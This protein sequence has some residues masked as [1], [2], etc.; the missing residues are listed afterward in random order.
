[1]HSSTLFRTL[2]FHGVNAVYKIAPWHP[3]TTGYDSTS[4][5]SD[6]DSQNLRN[7]GFN[8]VRLGVMW[9]GVEPGPRGQ[10]NQTYL[11]QIETIVTNLQTQGIYVILDFHQDL[12]HR[13][14][15]GEGVP[16]YVYDTCKRAEPADTKPFPLPAVNASYPLDENGDPALDSCLSHMFATYYLSAEVGAGF[17]CLYDNVDNLWDAFAGYWVAI[18]SRFKSFNNVLGYELMNEPWAGDVYKNPKSLLPHFAEQ[19]YLQPLYQHLHKVTSVFTFV[20][21]TLALTV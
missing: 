16:D 11:D 5:L 18:A 17:Q 3:A 15:C 13:K 9:P 19:Q 2:I 21:L 12:W 7:W 20:T 4:T 6:Q 10:Y 8:I 1:M 14:F